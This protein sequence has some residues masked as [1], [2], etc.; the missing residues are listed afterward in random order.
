MQ[1][2]A[3]GVLRH[4]AQAL[5]AS[6]TSLAS[7]AAHSTSVYNYASILRTFSASSGARTARSCPAPPRTFSTSAGQDI[8]KGAGY[9][10]TN[11][12]EQEPERDARIVVFGG[13]GFV[14][15]A[16]CREALAQGLEVTAVCRSGQ[17]K[18]RGPWVEATEWVAADAL[19]PSTYIDAAGL[20]TAMGAVSC[21][22]AFGSNE[23]MLRVCGDANVAA[24]EACK[25]AGVPRFA[26]VSVHDVH[27]E[28]AFKPVP[29]RGYFEGKAKSEDAL[30]RCYGSDGVAMRPGFVYGPRAV[31]SFTLPLQMVGGPIDGLL[32]RVPALDAAARAVGSVPLVGAAAVPPVDV[33]VLARALVAA[34][35][36][37]SVPGGAMDVWTIR[38]RYA[39]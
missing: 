7:E 27:R 32:K 14:G 30:A 31:G 26:L 10:G 13:N 24:I 12:G 18:E 15:S 1:R 23:F 5:S 8:G 35:T 11:Q 38:E 4:A 21:V 22:G 39:R 36:D 34:A 16:V 20:E 28:G 25:A 6:G 19:N 29:L 9:E 3:S 37:P 17:P 2:I 33:A